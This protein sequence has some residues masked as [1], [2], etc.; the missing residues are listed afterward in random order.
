MQSVRHTGPKP[1]GVPIITNEEVAAK[2]NSQAS[3]G[4]ISALIAGFS[5]T[6]LVE[7]FGGR[8]APKSSLDDF[9]EL[10]YKVDLGMFA[11][12][13]KRHKVSHVVLPTLRPTPLLTP[14]TICT[15]AGRGAGSGSDLSDG[16]WRRGYT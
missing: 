3:L 1:T 6:A 16:P 7:T 9:E 12:R 15:L 14:L 4:M 5:L 11:R 10:L 8:E 13:R 2:A